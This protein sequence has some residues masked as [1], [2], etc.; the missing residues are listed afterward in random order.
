[1]EGDFYVVR[2]LNG[3]FG[4]VRREDIG[5]DALRRATEIAFSP[6]RPAF[7]VHALNASIELQWDCP[8]CRLPLYINSGDIALRLVSYYLLNRKPCILKLLSK[9]KPTMSPFGLIPDTT[10]P[11]PAVACGTSM[12]V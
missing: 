4:F 8:R 12:L 2:K 1:M 5:A 7:Q 6:I 3:Q 9:K 11:P 10:G